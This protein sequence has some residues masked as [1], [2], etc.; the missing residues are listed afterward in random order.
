M[1]D[2]SGDTDVRRHLAKQGTNIGAE[3]VLLTA[4]AAGPAGK[5]LAEAQGVASRRTLTV[6]AAQ[7]L[8]CWRRGTSGR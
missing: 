6:V 5:P 7:W 4:D 1:P 2:N 3:D 8:P